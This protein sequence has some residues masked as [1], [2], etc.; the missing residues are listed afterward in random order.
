MF[1][2]LLLI[3]SLRLTWL[4]VPEINAGR[5]HHN[6]FM[7]FI[8]LL[9]MMTYVNATFNIAVYYTIGSRYRHTFWT[10]LGRRSREEH[11]CTPKALA[12]SST[13]S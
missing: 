10:L 5:R 7:M 8:W 2:V 11:R 12:T 1:T 3:T 6:F 9:D 4:F 13:N